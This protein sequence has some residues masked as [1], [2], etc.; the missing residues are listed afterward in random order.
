DNSERKFQKP[1]NKSGHR[2]ENKGPKKFAADKFDYADRRPYAG[3]GKFKPSSSGYQTGSGN[4]KFKFKREGFRSDFGHD[5]F[6]TKKE[7]FSSRAGHDKFQPKN[8]NKGGFDPLEY[9]SHRPETR[10]MT[11]RERFRA[12]MRAGDRPSFG[13]KNNFAGTGRRDNRFHR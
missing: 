4:D 13:R 5:K 12:E 6:R 2:F 10:V 8:E 3:V 9:F 1:F 7:G 11:D